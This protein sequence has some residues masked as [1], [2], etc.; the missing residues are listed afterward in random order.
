MQE[1]RPDPMIEQALRWQ[2]LMEDRDASD[3]DRAAFQTWLQADARH[4]EAWARAQQVWARAGEIAPAVAPLAVADRGAAPSSATV[5]QFPVHAARGGLAGRRRMLWAAGLAAAAVPAAVL[6]ARPDLLADH[7][8]A[9]G[10]RRKVA[11][12]DGS[13]VELASSSS[14]SLDFSAR[15]RRV[16]LHAGEAFFA[17]ARDDAR[18]FVVQ[19][20]GGS[21]EALGT[22]FDVK[23]HDA[24]V[25][26]TVVEHAVVVSCAEARIVLRQGEQ[27][28]YGANRLGK[29]RDV[30][31]AQVE[32]WRRDRLVFHDTPL[33]DVIADLE[34][35][36]AGRIVMTDQRLREM[37][38]TAVFDTG[39][40]D[41][42]L[43]SIA[44]LLRLRVRRITP[45]LV[46]VSA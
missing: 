19:A 41:A 46:I 3:S 15:E 25:S 26:V 36:H 7:A 27:V 29:V 23:R 4:R 11:F 20:A 39:Q 44:N 16:V 33:G 8:T 2:V 28:R 12:D 42:A 5:A 30:D 6:L 40:A 9:V 35:Y 45:F 43:E 32:A 31:L 17:V 13:I 14:L 22:S 18:P 10:E 34:R 21:A 38:V 37:P 1:T 24:D